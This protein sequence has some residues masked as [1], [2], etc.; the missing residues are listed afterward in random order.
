MI[1][2][3]TFLLPFC[4][5]LLFAKSP[6]HENMVQITGGVFQMGDTLGTRTTTVRT[7]F[8]DKTEVTNAEYQKCVD[9]KACAPAHYADSLGHG[10][11]GKDWPVQIVPQ[12]YRAAGLPAVCVDYFEAE[13][14]CAWAG[15]RLPTEAEWEYAAR[16]GT[17]TRYYWGNALD[18]AYL[19][20][21][22]NSGLIAHP[23]A[24]KKAN[25][26][27][28]YDMCGNVWEWCDDWFDST[29]TTR[30]FKGGSWVSK[31]EAVCSFSKKGA[32]PDSKFDNNGFRCVK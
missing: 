16:A 18:T 14:Y 21:K 24:A 3:L 10:Y 29:K 15:K 4:C 1:S 7:F 22:E 9:A 5:A 26:W 30:V 23:P 31:A 32:P 20:Y 12:A 8:M 25:A 11:D 13:K 28:L 2:R 17:T 19:W 27:G 6:D